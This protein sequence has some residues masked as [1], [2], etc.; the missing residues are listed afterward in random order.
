[1]ERAR[2]EFM[3]SRGFG[4]DSIFSADLMFVVESVDIRYRAPARLDEIIEATVAPLKIGAASLLL[5]QTVRRDGTLLADGR[6]RIGCVDKR[7]LKPKK[8]PADM[9]AGLRGERA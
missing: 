5:A 9:L 4:R 7:T 3:R 8:M 1:M 6:V 2:T